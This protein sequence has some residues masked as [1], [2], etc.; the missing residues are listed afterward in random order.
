MMRWGAHL[1]NVW[2]RLRGWRYRSYAHPN[3]R[4]DALAAEAGL[5][6]RDERTTFVWRVVL[7]ERVP[8]TT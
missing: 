7:Y 1:L 2:F 5:R 6:P 8:A 4:V 3:A